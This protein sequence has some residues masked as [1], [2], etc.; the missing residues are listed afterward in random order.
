M[1]DD[2]ILTPLI[3]DLVSQKSD[4]PAAEDLR[5]ALNGIIERYKLHPSVVI[6]LLARLSAGYI[7][8]TQKA[9]NKICD[10]E[11]VEE[12]FQNF[13]TA[14]LTDLDMSDLDKEIEK[15]KNKGLN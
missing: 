2:V 3:R 11:V 7:H 1:A 5:Q 14:H 8:L 9:Y 12:D 10:D 15:M 6:S 4:A 13:L